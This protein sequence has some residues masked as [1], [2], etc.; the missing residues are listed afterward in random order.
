MISISKII[1]T[2]D[3]WD[4]IIQSFIRD[5]QLIH[6]KGE[7]S[8]SEERKGFFFP[9]E[10][11]VGKNLC[12]LLAVSPLLCCLILFYHSM[13]KNKKK[14]FPEDSWICRLLYCLWNIASLLNV[15]STDCFV[16]GHCLHQPKFCHCYFSGE[17]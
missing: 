11:Q 16:T 12:Q 6:S 17:I 2:T 13:P 5:I 15:F 3:I 7:N 4:S 10:K 1:Y 14:K 9:I 8:A